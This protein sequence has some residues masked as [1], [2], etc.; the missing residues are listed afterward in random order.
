[1]IMKQL[2]IAIA[3]LLAIGSTTDA[4]AQRVRYY[5][6]PHTNVYYN[7]VSGDYW[8]YDESKTNWMTVKALPSSIT[9]DDNNRFVIIY[10]GIDVYK[11]N[12]THKKKYKVKKSGEI[13][14]KQ[15]D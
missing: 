1:M 11:E 5:Y 10:D 12:S 6:Y 14:E 2:I 3:L 9:I 8:Y 4:N 15:K 13:K 7:T